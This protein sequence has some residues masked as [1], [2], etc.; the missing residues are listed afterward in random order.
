MRG[1]GMKAVVKATTD[2]IGEDFRLSEANLLA[3]E[4]RIESTC[5]HQIGNKLK[6]TEPTAVYDSS[7]VSADN[8]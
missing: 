4:C 3:Q 8:V 2:L 7:I 1:I 6:N 5:N